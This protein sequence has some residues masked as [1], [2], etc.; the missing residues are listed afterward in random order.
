MCASLGD[1]MRHNSDESK[2]V[3]VYRG[4][5]NEVP[6]TEQFQQLKLILPNFWR[7]EV[8]SQRTAGVRHGDRSPLAV[9]FR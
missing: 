4:G 6:H 1:N 8:Q 3:L 5:R 2:A 9:V 7:T